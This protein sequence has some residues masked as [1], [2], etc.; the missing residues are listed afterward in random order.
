MRGDLAA[1]MVIHA[2]RSLLP[3]S[4]Y[5][6]LSM[7]DAR[8]DVNHDLERSWPFLLNSKHFLLLEFSVSILWPF[9]ANQ[10]QFNS[11][12]TYVLNDCFAFLVQHIK[13]NYNRRS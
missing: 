7:A 12:K 11:G 13:S 9:D 1:N 5:S 3:A 8:S 10:S 2:M 4:L 6:V